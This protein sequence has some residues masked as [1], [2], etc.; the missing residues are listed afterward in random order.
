M[1]RGS[2]VG[3]IRKKIVNVDLLSYYHDVHFILPM[4]KI[5]WN[6][7][8]SLTVVHKWDE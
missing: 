3:N 7:L 2:F 8:K 4:I 6:Q 5:S 1:G